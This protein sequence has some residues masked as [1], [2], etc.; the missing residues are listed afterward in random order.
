VRTNDS[1]VTVP[2][3][4]DP[5][6][7]RRQLA[8]L[9]TGPPAPK[10]NQFARTHGAY[11]AIARDRLKEKEREVFDALS[12]DAPLRDASGD[13]SRHDTVPVALLAEVLCRLEDVNSFLSARGY[14]DD[15]GQVRPA[16]ELAGRMRREASDYLDALG[17]TPK[18]RAKLG[19]DLSRTFD[20]A[21]HFAE[22]DGGV[23]RSN[24]SSRR[25]TNT[26]AARGAVPRRDPMAC[27]RLGCSELA[28]DGAKFCMRCERIAREWREELEA[29]L[30]RELDR[31]VREEA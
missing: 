30:D 6:R 28:R 18:S 13:L 22:L 23:V 25:P 15:K 8:N 12:D 20:L 10:G 21:E 14:L 26:T 27:G 29:E 24:G 7:Q 1:E 19:L 5:R 3:S 11:A 31:R 17:M 9:Q 4:K 16:A 2:L